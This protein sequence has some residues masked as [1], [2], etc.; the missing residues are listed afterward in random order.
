MLKKLRI[1]KHL[2]PKAEKKLSKD[3]MYFN[4][5]YENFVNES[6]KEQYVELVE[7]I[8]EN[9][10][11]LYEEC[12]VTPRLF[13]I[14]A[15]SDELNENQIIDLYKNKLNTTIKINYTKPMIDG[16]STIIYEN[17][18]KSIVKTL[19]QEGSDI[20]L[21]HVKTYLPF[22]ETVYQFNRSILIPEMAEKP[23]KS[24]LENTTKEY[25]DFVQESAEDILTKIEQKVRL[26]SSMV[27]PD[28]F[29]KAVDVDGVN[30]PKMAGISIAIDGNFNDDD[31]DGDICPASAAAIDPEI[32]E[33]LMDDEEAEGFEGDS[34]EDSVPELSVDDASPSTDEIGA[35]NNDSDQDLSKANEGEIDPGGI[36]ARLPGDLP[37]GEDISPEDME[38]FDE[39]NSVEDTS[40]ESPD[41]GSDE[42]EI[43]DEEKED[44]SE[45]KNR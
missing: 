28:M 39:F 12:D 33:E 24:F 10:I 40:A 15:E 23:I 7:S 18:L 6:F 17:E 2:S 13:S 14:A 30:A 31:C 4:Y 37:T 29:D 43:P 3:I 5:L 22:E 44:V 16:S 34:E 19:I 11:K 42:D 21:E 26:L 27:S 41:E 20:D 35:P 45:S 36:D 25:N 32:A 8:F 9:T 38:D 1:K